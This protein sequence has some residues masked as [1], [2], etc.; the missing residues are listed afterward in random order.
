MTSAIHAASALLPD[1]W[2]DQVRLVVA[3]GRIARIERGVP[4]QEGDERAAWLIPGMPN[5]HSHAFQRAIAGRGEVRGAG[6]DSFWSWR[7]A[8]YRFVERLDPEAMRA[9]AALAYAEMLEAGFTRVGEFH[10]LHNAPGG[11]RYDQPAAMAEA[12]VAA[13]GETGIALT[14][15]PVFYAYAGF[16]AQ[17]P[18]AEQARFL[19]D[20]DGYAALHQACEGAL[21]ALPDA[22]IGVAP[23]S[24]RAVT[25]EQ[26]RALVALAGDRPVHIHIA[27]QMREVEQCLAWSGRRPVEWLLDNAQVAANWCLVHATHM[28]PAETAA[29]AASGAVAGLCPVTE[30][31]LGDGLFP[32]PAYLAAGGAWGVGSDSNVRIDLFEE[33][34]WFE[35]GQ[36]LVLQRR[37]VAA[38]NEGQSTGAVLIEQAGRGGAQALAGEFGLA[39]GHSADFVELDARHPAFAAL[40]AA[41]RMDATIFAAGRE[42]VDG[43]WR[44][45]RKVVSGGRH[46]ARDAIEADYAATLAR[47]V[48]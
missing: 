25:P 23:H 5:L 44:R 6:E 30:A 41:L 29:L 34:R 40:P 39:E 45:G 37:N 13:A 12:L 42:A 33:L 4:P 38:R 19:S 32:A 10:Y 47:L 27:E 1:G 18:Q 14:L 26:L 22:R 48:A 35:Y 36:R 11:A 2:A 21:A 31:N 16:G 46:H 15:L 17:P 7:Q 24:L 28:T 20:L 9:I 43:V 8:M 3:D